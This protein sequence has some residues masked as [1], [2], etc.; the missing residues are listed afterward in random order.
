MRSFGIIAIALVDLTAAVSLT[1]TPAHAGEIDLDTAGAGEIRS[2]LED[3]RQRQASEEEQL[4]RLESE[5]TALLAVIEASERDYGAIESQLE[6]ATQALDAAEGGFSGTIE[7]LGDFRAEQALRYEAA[8]QAAAR[9]EA[10]EPEIP[11]ST[12]TIA[13]L[14][15]DISRAGRA[16]EAAEEAEARTRVTV[17]ADPP[18]GAN[19]IVQFAYDQ[20]GKPYGYGKT[21]PDAFD[22]SG[23]VAAAYAQSGVSLNRTSQGQWSDS[24]AISR[25]DLSPGDLVFSYG[26]GHIAI[27][28]GGG[29]VIHASKPGD[30]V[31]IAPMD[32]MPVSGYRRVQ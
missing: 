1:A 16:L 25:G 29:Q 32:V 3:L 6:Q 17:T 20:L 11:R 4:D 22:C 2:H 14:A 10:V 31:K 30:T 24:T 18:A 21:G 13:K 28:V 26:T 19:D 23:L 7:A 9:L 5:R 8:Q 27:Y 15:G 12:E